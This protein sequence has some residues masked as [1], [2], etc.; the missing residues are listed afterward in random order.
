MLCCYEFREY[1]EI[2]DFTAA[3]NVL[4]YRLMGLETGEHFMASLREKLVKR[5]IFTSRDL[6]KLPDKS[7]VSV[8]GL[9]LHPHRP[10]TRSGKI[11]VFF[12]LE[13][14]FGLIEVVVFEDVYMKFGSAIFGKQEVL[15]LCA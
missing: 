15:C 8:S 1:R 3:E 2:R 14:E 10:P 4:E 5:K 13:D 7:M 9:L 6:K 11:T 12:S